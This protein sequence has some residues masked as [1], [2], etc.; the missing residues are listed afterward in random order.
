M[1]KLEAHDKI[2]R[3]EEWRKNNNLVS[4]DAFL[5]IEDPIARMNEMIAHVDEVIEGVSSYVFR[6]ESHKPM[7]KIIQVVTPLM[8]LSPQLTPMLKTDTKEVSE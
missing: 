5:N 1:E 8:Y 7:G 6:R 4:F 3:A 2:T